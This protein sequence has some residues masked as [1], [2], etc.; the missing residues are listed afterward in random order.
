[1][2][3]R[4][5]ILSTMDPPGHWISLFTGCAVGPDF[6]EPDVEAPEAYRTVVMPA[7]TADDL[8]WWA[9]FDDPLLY[10]LVTTALENNRDLK[11]AVS[12]IEQARATVG[13]TRADQYPRLDGEAGAQTGNVNGGSRS[14]DTTSTIYLSAPLNLGNRLLG[15]IQTR[16]P[17]RRAP[18]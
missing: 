16:P 7:E 6:K 15:Q 10:D 4:T 9:L 18:T 11:I 17:K 5:T 13:F 14:S 12:R 1:M 8:K 3:S 2:N